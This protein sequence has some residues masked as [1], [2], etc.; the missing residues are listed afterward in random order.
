MRRHAAAVNGHRIELAA[1]LWSGREVVAYDGRTVS[2]KRS[3]LYVTV[4]SFQVD[5]GGE[6]VVYEVNFIT[7][8]LGFDV[9]YAI[10]RNGIIVAHHP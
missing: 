4:H 9:G 2:S 1:S 8:W 7:G 6:S 5:E 10:R 3:I